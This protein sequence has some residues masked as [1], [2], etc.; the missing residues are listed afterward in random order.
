MTDG[1]SIATDES[2]TGHFGD[3]G[4][5]TGARMLGS[6]ATSRATCSAAHDTRNTRARP[7]ARRRTSS[8]AAARYEH[9]R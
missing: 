9:D 3:D 1:L 2:E 6:I 4:Q 7:H 5:R 8:K